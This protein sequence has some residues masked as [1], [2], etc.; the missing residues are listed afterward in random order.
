[1]TY[2]V[3]DDLVYW[4]PACTCSLKNSWVTV[5][6]RRVQVECEKHPESTSHLCTCYTTPINTAGSVYCMEHG[7]VQVMRF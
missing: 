2:V 4:E 6:G 5:D 7:Y 3:L 1:M